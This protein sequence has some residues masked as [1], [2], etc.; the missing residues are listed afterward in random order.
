MAT[1][2]APFSDITPEEFRRVTEVTYL[3]Q[4][5][6]TMTALKRMRPHERGVIVQVGSA[7]AYRPIPLQSPYCG[8]KHAVV[9]F[10]DSLRSELIREG[11]V[12]ALTVVHLPAVNTP[13][14]D[15]SRNKM[16]RRH[17]PVPPIFQPEVAADAIHFAAHHPR[18]EL[19]VGGPTVMA[20]LADKVAPGL[21]DHYLAESGYDGQLTDEPEGERPDNLFV[22]VAGDYA[23]HGRFDAE[24]SGHSPALAL[25]KNRDSLLLLDGVTGRREPRAS[26]LW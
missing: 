23:A 9:G 20:I 26:G 25:A 4:V 6:G 12:I 22:S 13:Q 3:G 24:A 15:W 18:R 19:W 7:L 14:F 2:L 8:A 11:S 1:V 16:G 10:T 21:L 5:Y 17:L